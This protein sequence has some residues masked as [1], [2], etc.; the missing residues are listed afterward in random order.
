M[1]GEYYH[2][3]TRGV[4]KRPVFRSAHDYDH[5]MILL[6]LS[7]DKKKL[8]FG[9]LR[10]KYGGEPLI[11]IFNGESTEPMVGIEAYALMPNHFH[12]LLKETEENAISRFMLKLTTAYSMYFNVKYGRTGA[13]VSRPFRSRHIT[14]DEYLRWVFTY[15]NLNPLELFQHDWKEVGL[16]DREAARGFM[17]SYKYSSFLDC[18][19]NDRAES[20]ILHKTRTPTM[21]SG[22][23]EL[24]TF[25]KPGSIEG[26]P[27][28]RDFLNSI[29]GNR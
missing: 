28:Y 23:D 2:V 14:D 4:E 7:N 8:Q 18:L 26:S 19:G 16:N 5:F 21:T 29:L 6:F 17:S 1:V 25:L 11:Q 22:F 10:K 13:L 12:L 3:F 20:K 9:N 27:R 24:M 15:I